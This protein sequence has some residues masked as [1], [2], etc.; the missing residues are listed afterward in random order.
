MTARSKKGNLK[1]VKRGGSKS[2]GK[3]ERQFRA[4]ARSKFEPWPNDS[5][6]LHPTDDAMRECAVASRLAYA[7][8]R[9]TK[10]ELV[11][12]CEELGDDG[13][14]KLLDVFAD[15]S[16]TFKATL[17]LLQA[18]TNRVPVS[19]AANELKKLPDRKRGTTASE[20]TP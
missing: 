6:P 4:I 7:T 1:T 17:S 3:E 15:A 20:A 14:N 2:I 9:K 13:L 12:A 10:D 16:Q 8:M 19:A 5:G 18:A 11:G